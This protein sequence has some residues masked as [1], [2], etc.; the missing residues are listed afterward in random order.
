MASCILDSV[1]LGASENNG[2]GLAIG[3]PVMV[4]AAVLPQWAEAVPKCLEEID[5]KCTSEPKE[6][7]HEDTS[8]RL[9]GYRHLSDL[10][11]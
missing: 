11:N 1:A 6:K 7:N 9:F 10:A 3:L 4:K 2:F 5:S 8:Q